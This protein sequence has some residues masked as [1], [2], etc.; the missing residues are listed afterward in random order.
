[1]RSALAR[2]LPGWSAPWRSLGR[3][4]ALAAAALVPAAAVR[5]VI[6]DGWH[7]AFAALAVIGLYGAI[8]LGVARLLGLPEL[9]AWVGRFGRKRR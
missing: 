8:Y 6:P 2:R 1:L 4:T 5:W 3:S 9:E 7:P